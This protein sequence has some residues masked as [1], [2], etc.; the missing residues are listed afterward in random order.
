MSLS[1]GDFEFKARG[2]LA[3]SMGSGFEGFRVVG[4][5]VSA[6][7][8]PGLQGQG[9]RA[10]RVWQDGKTSWTSLWPRPNPSRQ[11]AL[12]KPEVSKKLGG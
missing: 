5:W 3:L 9:V 6:F 4:V 1:W 10:W 8:A 7:R 12:G 11:G 2:L